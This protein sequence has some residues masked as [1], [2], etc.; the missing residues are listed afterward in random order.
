MIFHG[1]NVVFD[2]K[3]FPS[4]SLAID[5]RHARYRYLNSTV[6]DRR[7]GGNFIVI[8]REELEDED[9]FRLAN[10][11]HHDVYRF[12]AVEPFTDLKIKA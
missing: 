7:D 9:L 3:R 8:G 12:I 4:V 11:G 6:A 10:L 5:E 2:D 1:T